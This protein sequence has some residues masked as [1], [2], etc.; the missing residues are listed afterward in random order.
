MGLVY[1]PTNLPYKIG[2]IGKC[3]S[4]MD[5]VGMRFVNPLLKY[6]LPETNSSF[7]KI[8]CAPKG[9]ESSSNHQ[10]SGATLDGQNPANQLILVKYPIIYKV[11][12]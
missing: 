1:L 2:H 5:P 9:N 11:G 3:T 10:F 7:L 4:P 6:T 8:G 12:R